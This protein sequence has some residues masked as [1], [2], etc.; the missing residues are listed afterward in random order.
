L[1]GQTTRFEAHNALSVLTV[2]DN[3]F[4][5]LNFWTLH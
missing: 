3:G 5:E 1:L 2:I 4:G